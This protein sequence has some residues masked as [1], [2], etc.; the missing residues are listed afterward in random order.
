MIHIRTLLGLALLTLLLAACGKP[1]A[2]RDAPPAFELKLYHVPVAQS[3]AIATQLTK[4]LVDSGYLVG[5]QSKTTMNV[6]QPFPGAVLVLA[7]ARLQPSIGSAIQA[8][9][10]A[11][12]TPLAPPPAPAASGV[13]IRAW[14]VQA[15]QG[16]GADDAV[17]GELAP[18]L[19]TLRQSLGASHFVLNEQVALVVDAEDGGAIT[20]SQDHSYRFELSPAAAGADELRLDYRDPS[21]ATIRNLRATVKVPANHYVVLAQAPAPAAAKGAAEALLTLLIV[22]AEH[23]PTTP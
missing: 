11:A 8:L 15:I 4:V 16:A 18:T 20:T 6:S 2:D 9:N 12:A 23:L 7:P 10:A 21:G 14:V 13:R 22:H 3:Q 5:T 1:F 17:L 19:K